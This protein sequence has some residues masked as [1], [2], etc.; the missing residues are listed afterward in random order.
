MLF[1]VTRR[2]GVCT[3]LRLYELKLYVDVVLGIGLLSEFWVTLRKGV[4]TRV[5]ACF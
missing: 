3:V 4:C 5:R 2:K 1:W